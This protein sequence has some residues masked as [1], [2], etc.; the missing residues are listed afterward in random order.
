MVKDI[1]NFVFYLIYFIDPEI[2]YKFRNKKI[3][4]TLFNGIY[5]FLDY[6]YNLH[7][8]LNET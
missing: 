7:F 2:H 3:R 4:V 8:D 6:F 5:L 1:Y